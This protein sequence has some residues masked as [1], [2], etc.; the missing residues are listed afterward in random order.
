MS[1]KDHATPSLLLLVAGIKGAIGSTLATAVCALRDRPDMVLPSLT[2]AEKFHHI[3]PVN[4]VYLAGWD[5]TPRSLPAAVVHHGVLPPHLR[6]AYETALAEVPVRPAPHPEQPLSAQIGQLQADIQAF[7]G[8]F[9][10]CRPVFIDLLP[11]APPLDLTHVSRTEQ[12]SD[13]VSPDFPDLA[14]ALAAI[15]LGIP[16]VNFTP[17]A[18]E[19]PIV[20]EEA[21]RRGVPISGRDGK[22]GQT[23]LKVVLASA[24]KARSLWIDGW[25]SL[26]LLG[27]DDGKNLQDPCRAA[28]K[29][30]N[31]TAVL[32][33]VLGYP[34]GEQAYGRSAHKVH[35]DFYPPRGDAKEAW[36]LIDLRGLF[37]LPMSIR[38]NLHARDSILAAPLVLDLSRWMAALQEAGYRGAVSELAFFYKSPVGQGAPI[39]FPEQI[40]A[41]Q[42][43]EAACSPNTDQRTSGPASTP[44]V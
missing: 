8:A 2:T 35:I 7:T 33:A 36:D 16:V 11:A 27:N 34:V 29:L 19:Q 30:Q 37:G 38:I 9:R 43:M 4:K 22:T 25:Y 3:G 17:N 28:E 13:T 1:P 42:E 10:H 23:Y 6:E 20:V 5:C 26:N 14:Y 41:L 12:L 40:H 21:D 18:V 31:K 39:T 44:G 24:L 32:D 15:Q